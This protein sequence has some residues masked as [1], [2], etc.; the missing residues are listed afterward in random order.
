MLKWKAYCCRPTA[1][2]ASVCKENERTM[3]V[4]FRHLNHFR[5]ECVTV[6]WKCNR[7]E[8]WNWHTSPFTPHYDSMNV[9]DN[10]SNVTKITWKEKRKEK[11]KKKIIFSWNSGV[12][13]VFILLHYYQRILS[14]HNTNRLHSWSTVSCVVVVT[15]RKTKYYIMLCK[16]IGSEYKKIE[17]KWNCIEW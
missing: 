7:T 12:Q 15:K 10:S 8:F 16:T 3:F 2:R 9:K 11:R 6:M 13:S 5:T 4:S 1:D 17:W 14:F